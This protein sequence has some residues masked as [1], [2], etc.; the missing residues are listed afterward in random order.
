LRTADLDY[1]KSSARVGHLDQRLDRL[2]H[3]QEAGG[4]NPLVPTIP[5]RYFFTC[6]MSAVSIFAYFASASANA[7]AYASSLAIFCFF[8]SPSKT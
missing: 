3:T 6:A 7:F 8:Q 2:L 1:T 4:S 5:S